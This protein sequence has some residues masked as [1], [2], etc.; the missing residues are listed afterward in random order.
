MIVAEC[1]RVPEVAVTVIMLVPAGV[2]V[3]AAAFPLPQPAAAKTASKITARPPAR[4]GAVEKK[5]NRSLPK[6]SPT[7]R[8]PANPAAS[9]IRNCEVGQRLANC[10]DGTA[11]I[12]VLRALVVIVSMGIVLPPGV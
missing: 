7:R 1:E 6:Y 12:I 4:S 9:N 11:P 10:P 2:P 3:E 5:P 8:N